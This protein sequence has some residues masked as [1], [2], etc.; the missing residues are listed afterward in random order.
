MLFILFEAKN[1]GVKVHC[2]V[3]LVSL[4]DGMTFEFPEIFDADEKDKKEQKEKDLVQQYEEALE[5]RNKGVN[6]DSEKRDI[7]PW[8]RQLVIV[9]LFEYFSP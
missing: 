2:E 4:Q 8:F 6:K 1:S 9:I 3:L 7:P 5:E